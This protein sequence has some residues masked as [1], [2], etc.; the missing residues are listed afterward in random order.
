MARRQ[1]TE[2]ENCPVCADMQKLGKAI[3][4]AVAHAQL[5][6]DLSSADLM[7]TLMISTAIMN[8]L[9]VKPDMFDVATQELVDLFLERSAEVFEERQATNLDTHQKAKD[10]LDQRMQKDVRSVPG[11]KD[12]RGRPVAFSHPSNLHRRGTDL[13]SAGADT[14]FSRNAFDGKVH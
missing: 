5:E 8:G 13:M 4:D 2:D 6:Y 1:H 9:S 3:Y 10:L 12:R 7:R 11:E 14:P